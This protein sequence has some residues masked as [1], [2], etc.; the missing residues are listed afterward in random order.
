MEKTIAVVDDDVTI[1]KTY[2]PLLRGQGYDVHWFTNG[3]DFMNAIGGLDVDLVLLDVDL[4]K[5]NGW[6]IHSLLKQEYPDLHVIFLTAVAVESAD[7]AKG[8]EAGAADYI[9]KAGD[10]R[11]MLAR[12]RNKLFSQGSAPPQEEPVEKTIVAGHLALDPG[13]LCCS[14]KGAEVPL[15]L[16]EFRLL[17]E[18]ARIPGLVKTR[19]VL[20]AVSK[21]EESDANERSIDSHIKRIRRK[22]KDVDRAFSGIRTH[23]GAGYSYRKDH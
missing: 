21:G 10:A 5:M 4:P 16:T 15:T 22:I 6:Q 9:R 11:V 20:L 2:H 1:Q 17:E 14:W 8:L 7:E 19:G 13:R 12:I 3:T 23:N 18:M